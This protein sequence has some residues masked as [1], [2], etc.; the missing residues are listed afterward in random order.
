[1]ALP[2]G[3]RPTLSP[4]Q[5][6]NFQR[7]QDENPDKINDQ[8]K[9]AIQQHAEYYRLPTAATKTTL[10]TQAKNVMQQAGKGFFEGFTTLKSD[11]PPTNDAEAIARNLGHL[12]GFVGYVPTI[13]MKRLGLEN[14]ANAL[15]ALKGMSVPMTAANAAQRVASRAVKPLYNRALSNRL[16][17]KSTAAKFLQSDITQDVALGAF[18]LGVAS[19]VSSWQ[20]GVDEMMEGMIFGAGAGAVFRGLGNAVR[21]GNE[22]ADK[23]IRGIAG[24]L[25][26]GL[27]SSIRGDTTPQ[28]IYNY[29]L[30]AYFGANES[31]VAKR[32][33]ERVL[34][35][36][37]AMRVE[38]PELIPEF[39]EASA[40][41]QKYVLDNFKPLE[42]APPEL[43]GELAKSAG[44]D[45][46]ERQKKAEDFIKTQEELDL[47][48]QQGL[49]KRGFVGE[50]ELEVRNY[51]EDVDPQIVPETLSQK[52][53]QFVDRFVTTESE[54]DAVRQAS[55]IEGQW[56]KLINEA[57][58]TGENPGEKMSQFMSENYSGKLAE[59]K[60]M[61]RF[62]INLGH[63]KIRE[64]R[65]LQVGMVENE[66]VKFL[67]W[68]RATLATTNLAGD[69]KFMVQPRKPMEDIY[70][71]DSGI[72]ESSFAMVDHIVRKTK[73]GNYTKIDI[74]DYPNYMAKVL[75]K[76]KY[77]DKKA[78]RAAVDREFGK[79]Y[80]FMNSK[81][82]HYFGGKGDSAN[83]FFQKFHPL[84][85]GKV[86]ELANNTYKQI[87][88]ISKDGRNTKRFEKDRNKFIF[89]Y[90]KYFGSKKA[91]ERYYNKAFLSN[92]IYD[93][94][95]NGFENVTI[96]NNKIEGLET[97]VSKGFINDA[98]AF[99]KRAQI[100]LTN[101]YSADPQIVTNIIKKN[102]PKV[103]KEDSVFNYKLVKDIGKEIPHKLGTPN[104]E[105]FQ[106]GDGA[107]YA[108]R[109]VIDALNRQA[110]LP[111]FG[112]TN[113]S[114]IYSPDPQ[115]G[116]L[117]GKYMIHPATPKLEKYMTNNDL[118]FIIPLSSAKQIGKRKG[119]GTFDWY[120]KNPRVINAET[121]QLPIKDI[122]VV[123]SEITSRKDLK[124]K[125]M[126]KQM[127]TNYMPYSFFDPVRSGFKSEDLYHKE[128]TK[129]FEGMYEDLVRNEINGDKTVN[130]TA[131]RYFQDPATYKKD[132]PFIIENLDKM[133]MHTLLQ[134][135]KT[136]GNEAFANKAYQKI[137][138]VNQEVIETIKSEGE[139]SEKEVQELKKDMIDYGTINERII[140]LMPDSV[141][142]FLHKFPRD[143]RMSVM[144]NYF[145]HRITRP[146]LG[147]S[148]SARMRPYEDGMAREG[149]TAELQKRDDIFFLGDNYKDM[150]IDATGVGI[151]GKIT[152]GELWAKKNKSE[153]LKEL[154]NA[155]VVRVPMDSMSGAHKLAFRGFTGTKDNGVLLHGRTMEALGGA[156][157]DGDKAFVF[158]GGKNAEGVG[159]G[160]K[161]EW[162]DL[163]DWSK[164]EYLGEDNIEKVGKQPK[165][166]K[167]LTET[168]ADILF[169]RKSSLTLQYSPN[170]RKEVSE[171]ANLGRNRLGSAVTQ[172]SY[173]KTA[174][175]AIRNSAKGHLDFKAKDGK[176]MIRAIPKEDNKSLADFR[177]R[178]RAAI[179]LSSDP[180]NEAGLNFTPLIKNQVN[181]LFEFKILDK[182]GNPTKKKVDDKLIL[183]LSTDSPIKTAMEINSGLYGKNF[184]TG[185]RHQM[186]EILDKLERID[187]PEYGIAPKDR[188]TFLAKLAE[189]VK[190]MDWGDKV[191]VRVNETKLNNL[192]RDHKEFQ[193]ELKDIEKILGRGST[194][195][196][197]GKHIELVYNYDL[198]DRPSFQKL[199]KNPPDRLIKAIKQFKTFDGKEKY[200]YFGK[201]IE[202]NRRTLYDIVL[203]AEDFIINDL[204]D[205]ASYRVIHDLSKNMSGKQIE[206]ISKLVDEVKKESYVY[207]QR[208]RKIDMN[209]KNLTETE[210]NDSQKVSEELYGEPQSR[211]L[212]QQ[213]IDAKILQQKQKLNTQEKLLYDS[214]MLGTIW[215]GKKD[216]VASKLKQTGE[217]KSEQYIKEIDDML[218]DS[219][220]TSLSRIG[221]ASD[222][223]PDVSV[224]RMLTEYQKMFDY[225]VSKSDAKFVEESI[226]KSDNAA[227]DIGRVS[228]IETPYKD[229]ETQKFFDE[230]QPFIG[231][232][233]G[234]EKLNQKDADLLNKIQSHLDHYQGQVGTKLNGLFRNV[235]QRD[236]NTATREDF[237][238]FEKYLTEIRNGSWWSNILGKP[239]NEIKKSYYYMFPKTIDM[240]TMR[241][242]IKLVKQRV[243]VKTKTGQVTLN[244]YQP[245]GTMVRIQTPVHEMTQQA[246]QRFEKEKGLWEDKIDPFINGTEDGRKIFAFAQAERELGQIKSLKNQ[247]NEGEIS[248]KEFEIYRS[249]YTNSYDNIKKE[250]NWNKIKNK[251]YEVQLDGKQRLVSGREIADRLIDITNKQYYKMAQ[252]IT[253]KKD[254]YSVNEPTE[255]D[256]IYTG[257]EKINPN[258]A[259]Y[260]TIEKFIKRMDKALLEGK[261]LELPEGSDGLQ[262]LVHDQ[263]V[264]LFA[265]HPE[266]QKSIRENKRPTGTRLRDNES[267]W[268]HYPTDPK[269]AKQELIKV[270]KSI[271][272]NPNLTK[273]Q[274][275]QRV[276]RQIWAYKQ[277]TNDWH[278]SL[279]TVTNNELVAEVLTEIS[280]KR[281]T[282][283]ESL[284]KLQNYQKIGSQQARQQHIPGYSLEPEMMNRYMKN[285][286]DNL[287]KHAA[288][289]KVKHEIEKFGQAFYKKTKD[290]K[291]TQRWK[292]FYTMYAQDA[293]GYPQQIPQRILDD[294][295]MGIKGTPFAWVND[296][297][298]LNFVNKARKKL[299]IN[300]KI[301]DLPEE[302]KDF[303]FNT[304]TGWSNL[305]AKYQL[306]TLLAHPKSAV[307]NLYG[308]SVHT[309]VSTGYG[310]FKNARD[311]SYLKR[312]VNSE[313][314]DK[315]DVQKWVQSLGVIEDFILY[316]AGF[317]P[318]FREK[319]FKEF[320]NEAVDTIKKDPDVKT[321]T[322]KQVASKYKITDKV[323]NSAAWFMR[324]PERTLRRDAFMAHYLQAREKFAGAITKY[325]D[326]ILIKMGKE[327]VKSTQFLYSA[328]FRPAFA[329]S[330][331]GKALTRFQLWAWNSVRFRGDAL[332][333]ARIH[334]FK[335]GTPEFDRFKRLAAMDLLMFGLANTF[336]Y[337]LFENTLPQPW[338]WAQDLADWSFGNEKE[339]SRAFFGTY[340]AA[341]APLQAITPPLARPL[342]GLFK[343]IVN[344]D[345]STLGGYYAWSMMPFGRVGYDIFGNVLQGGKGGLIQ[346]PYRMIE[347]ISGIPYQQIPRQIQKSFDEDMLRPTFVK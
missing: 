81:G 31:P 39:R 26:Q 333:E 107:I 57:R 82:F 343:A 200:P 96:K 110:G 105:Y 126:P 211:A 257:F 284:N 277:G 278:P 239:N 56:N 288:Q 247:L 119:V 16:D 150:P 5:V 108:P 265:R 102:Q 198:Y 113:K 279:E 346:N 71:K 17:A 204:S 189:D 46:K 1:M 70:Q 254:P 306:A 60:E 234:K 178:A 218:A 187:N 127:W 313:W 97:I 106:A 89:K 58:Q 289:I 341:L 74:A 125:R 116:A 144:R 59:T 220:K 342:P 196:P 177:E 118:Q 55:K 77:P 146:E 13:G 91:A 246:T 216:I 250:I 180:M 182:K 320:L 210:L 88:K 114:F 38:D 310:H 175:A 332:R 195:I 20:G 296:T 130:A 65:V 42:I 138:K 64:D 336:M 128:M 219:N 22:T 292:D 109:Y 230:Y 8:T 99:N 171:A 261:Q 330:A 15:K 186:W 281:S 208:H 217:A 87:A 151:K 270:I 322:L 236:L 190:G 122:K 61:D 297:G 6:R 124:N 232:K 345:Y 73:A 237:I 294:P 241:R 166:V 183:D 314:N 179:G 100:L 50:K 83:L 331:M 325:D 321:S 90:S 136:K 72:N 302:M 253:G 264:S 290:A 201:S 317:N 223:I 165:Y 229:K 79:L 19:A 53:K 240:D 282:A 260:F 37:R 207:A 337:S 267:Y 52:S 221:Y 252:I 285:V 272:E 338:S 164:N 295:K 95:L 276:T 327:G 66:P 301:K 104:S 304:V 32:L 213:K 135:M 137:M 62:W 29:V 163:Y 199:I 293:L 168:D 9:Q 233:T 140:R 334:G 27:P 197:K 256:R 115:N 54:I 10:T 101:G 160:F 287:Y 283:K 155:I 2:P 242:E 170:I 43:A 215:R 7:I 23:T 67:E 243:P 63:R 274:K 181:A 309:L 44:I 85:K 28:Q 273:E 258:T 84:L 147:N 286:F 323:F 326:P 159:A 149:I 307:A 117:L 319:R 291:L 176:T 184:E 202:S 131:E 69:R 120:R 339:R 303:D 143:Y 206:K 134:G 145:L 111:E 308:G 174:Y 191:F 139:L 12:A 209:N 14:T 340:P 269:V 25:F 315:K 121:Y 157:L 51:T 153:D 103:M 161:K 251:E 298:V 280:S 21:T 158:F 266:L 173:L 156:D 203:K 268:V 255:Y 226:N 185:K 30:G 311:I 92:I 34:A 275:K 68:D 192:Y 205:M 248:A 245:E 4:I 324:T 162:K 235:T 36:G 316:E 347:K 98:T 41:T 80:A 40:S 167:E 300:E 238:V 148:L 133:S 24:S 142:G 259:E 35:R 212:D 141:A 231:L 33:G 329:R 335:E 129:I 263:Q 225:T 227:K 94:R 262:R 123:L 11:K 93:I 328:P 188:N 271:D 47:S 76:T 344:D 169:D 224:K 45:I 214:M 305:E 132:L 194:A 249:T 172:V 154:F 152:L 48:D 299:G 18:H 193:K 3:F 78:G 244:V 222:S 86:N 312:F 112:G 318:K 75:S 228:I 49:V